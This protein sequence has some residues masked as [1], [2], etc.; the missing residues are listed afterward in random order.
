[1]EESA[2]SEVPRYPA[3]RPGDAPEPDGEPEPGVGSR[4]SLLLWA[5]L[6]VA[7]LALFLV[8]HL[9]GVLGPGGH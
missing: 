7:V 6:A 4:R 3:D 8:L 5:T 1:M 2:V 9:T